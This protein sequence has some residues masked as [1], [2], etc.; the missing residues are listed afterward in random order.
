MSAQIISSNSSEIQ[1][2]LTIQYDRSMLTFED[3][4]QSELNEAGM[5]AERKQLEN[6]DTDGS[7]IFFGKVKMTS[8]KKKQLKVYETPY[9]AVKVPRYVYQTS[10]GGATYSPLDHAARI[11]VNSTP[12]F[13]QMVS[14]K[15]AEMAAP[16][17]QKDFEQNHKRSTSR[18]TLR[19]IADVVGAI[20]QAKEDVWTYAIP[21]LPHP[22]STI[23]IGLDGAIMLYRDG[24]REAMCGSITLYDSDGERMFSTYSA[25]A[26]EYGKSSF[27]ERFTREIDKIKKQYPNATYVGVA[28]GA[29]D[30]WIFLEPFVEKCI[31]DFYHVSEYVSDAADALYSGK[32]KRNKRQAWFKE[33]LHNL[34][35]NKGE[36]ERLNKELQKAKASNQYSTTVAK[37]EKVKTYFKNHWHQMNYAE[38]L[39]SHH[40][41]G[42]GV[43]EAACKSLIKS[44]M[45]RSG[46]RWKKEGASMLLTLRA[47]VC[48]T[49][50]WEK[51]WKKIERYGFSPMHNI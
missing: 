45:C 49:G 2:L 11:V 10:D 41:I 22:V 35:H 36:A 31:L 23:A 47:L 21:E 6:L 19:D 28:D 37:L 25:E 1:I 14:W 20:A 17:A 8:K 9:G 3:N 30:N 42:S 44:R 50:V 27:I 51:F 4:L 48:S 39:D 7:P 13:A 43:T 18:A 46:M 33:T 24:Y 15:Y 5:L 26:P 32:T 34:K 29:P 40:P 12:K 38:A 16:Q